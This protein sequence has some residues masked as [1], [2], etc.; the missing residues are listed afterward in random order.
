MVQ[1]GYA[2]QWGKDGRDDLS[3]MKAMGANVVRLYCSMGEDEHHDHGAFLDRALELGL[4]VLAGFDSGLTTN[5]NNFDCFDTFKQTAL[6]AFKVGFARNHSWHPAIAAVI[7]LNEP[8]FLGARCTPANAAWCRVKA[9]LSAFDGVLAAEEEAQIRPN[10]NLTAAWSFAEMTSIDGKVTGPGIFGFQDMLAATAS[11]DLA[12]YT[13]HNELLAAYRKRWINSLN[14]QAPWSFVHDSISNNYEP[15]SPMP[16]M[17][18]EFGALGQTRAA[19]T[20]DL[21]DML[22]HSKTLEPFQGVVMFQFQSAYWKSGTELNFGLFA[23]G[24]TEVGTI[25]QVCVADEVCSGPF[26]VYCTT[27]DLSD[28]IK[29]PDQDHRAEAVADAWEGVVPKSRCAQRRAREGLPAIAI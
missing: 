18:T 4:L 16:W 21:Q 20:R 29:V 28:H 26:P 24:H 8:D 19:I 22:S 23:L 10:A 3:V 25:K 12:N 2:P 11:P 6:A 15:Y 9:V 7:L 5:C 1:E 13:P 14:T 27:S 17:I